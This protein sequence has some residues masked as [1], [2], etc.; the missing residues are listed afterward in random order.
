MK[1][2]NKEI[3]NTWYKN[4]EG[5]WD[6]VFR[7]FRLFPLIILYPLFYVLGGGSE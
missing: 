6:I 5:I 3:K 4:D 1:W 7:P 2:I